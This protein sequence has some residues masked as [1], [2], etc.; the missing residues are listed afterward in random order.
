MKTVI[1]EGLGVT[2]AI[3]GRNKV[4][5]NGLLASVEYSRKIEVEVLE[6][7]VNDYESLLQM[8]SRC[9]IVLNCVGPYRYIMEATNILL[10]L[11]L[12]I[13]HLIFIGTTEKTLSK[14]V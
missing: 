13:C 14:H 10:S 7:D 3:A 1:N 5:L 2:I 6:A 4:K 12:F 8:T 9:S 11:L